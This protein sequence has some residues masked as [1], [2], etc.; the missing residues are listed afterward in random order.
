MGGKAI[1]MLLSLVG[2]LGA[3]LYF[4]DSEAPVVERVESAALEGR[5][6]YQAERIRWQ[7]HERE[8]VE[9]GRVDGGPWK[10]TE[11]IVDLASRGYLRSIFN[12]WDSARLLAVPFEDD[13]EGRAKA[14]LS[15]P[16]LTLIV[17]W[18][19][20]RLD[21]EVGDPGP[22]GETRFLRRDGKIWQGGTALLETM[23]VGLDDLRER[24]VFRHQFVNASK[25][26]VEQVNA[27]GGRE[28]VG[29]AKVSGEWRLT[30]PIQGRADP[31]V[32]QRFI[33]D[34]LSL[35][36]DFFQPSI[37]R[38]P[39]RVADIKISVEGDG[40]PEQLD[41]WIE[42]GQV[43]GYLPERGHLF[44]SDNRQYGQV[45][46][47][48]MNTLRARI[49]VPM[50]ESTFE[51]LAEMIVDPGQGRG[52]RV[53]LR[54]ESQ[55]SSWRLLEP[56]DYPARAT[57]VNEAAHALQRL[58]ARK[59]VDDDGGVRPRAEDPRYG[60]DGARWS[61]TTRRLNEQQMHTVWFGA[62]ATQVDGEEAMIYCA[63][64]DEPDNVAIV[65]KIALETLQRPWTAY[66]DKSILQQNAQV[67]RLDLEHRDG[68]ARTFI[69][70]EDGS[71]ALRGA[72]GNRDEVGEYVEDTLR[73]FVGKR[74]VDMRE[75]FGEHD[76]AFVLMRRN[77]DAL[78]RV[79]IW[80][81]GADSRLVAR[82][83]TRPGETEQPIGVQ[84][85]KRD[86]EEL[87]KLWK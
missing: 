33:T 18:A 80:D 63:R 77:G 47:N 58:I 75:G 27:L 40:A 81:P 85:G 62:E 41:L 16:K 32:A 20:R 45:F 57:P 43:W 78:G 30:D 48:A 73:D 24:Q 53:R 87:R 74:V 72:P 83:Q 1:V 35:R 68:R 3:V 76:W 9:L 86:S 52:D 65:P 12:A 29:L 31:A 23:K 37:A 28:T 2:A 6:L 19:D 17:E 25:L 39:G 66:C 5:S 15:P 26:Q 21:I 14:G 71:W 34:V 13:D 7:F 10:I 55:T 46:V 84:L 11:P 44:I 51:Q 79:R 56:V 67:E 82:G 60:M 70:Q 59:F 54:R 38:Q 64:S 36:V 49:L 50:G 42:Q 69:I 4:T 22:L 8:P 61:L